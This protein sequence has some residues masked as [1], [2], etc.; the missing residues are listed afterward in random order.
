MSMAFI[1]DVMRHILG[2]QMEGVLT[3]E[4]AIT[5]PAV[6][7]KAAIMQARLTDFGGVT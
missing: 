3:A 7:R 4:Y 1:R 6:G 5:R 2:R